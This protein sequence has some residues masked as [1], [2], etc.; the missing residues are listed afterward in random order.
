[1]GESA[2]VLRVTR[3]KLGL[4][5]KKMPIFPGLKKG[6]FQFAPDTLEHPFVHLF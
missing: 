4:N 3:G 2:G 5:V 6:T 1:M